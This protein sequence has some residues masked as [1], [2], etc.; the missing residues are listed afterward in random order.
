MV[1][2]TSTAIVAVMSSSNTLSGGY[3]NQ[4]VLMVLTS[5]CAIIFVLSLLHTDL[6]KQQSELSERATSALAEARSDSLT[7]LNNRK[8]LVECLERKIHEQSYSQSCSS[9][10]FMDLDHFKNVN[11][12]LG[13]EAGDTLLEE[14]AHRLLRAMPDHECFR[15]GGDEFA[16]ILHGLGLEAAEQVCREVHQEVTRP[17]LLAGYP[18]SVGCSMGIAEF[19]HDLP[20]SVLMSRA[21]HAMYKAKFSRTSIAKFDKVMLAAATRTA[22]LTKKLREV[23]VSRTGIS[24]KYQPVFDRG[25]N[26]VELEGLFRWH[27]RDYHAI[28]TR[29]AIKIARQNHLLDQISL[30]VVERSQECLCVNPHLNLNINVEATQLLDRQFPDAL[31]EKLQLTGIACSRLSLEIGE[32]DLVT[33]GSKMARILAQLIDRG[34]SITVDDFGSSNA[35]L[36]R[37][38]ELGVS[39]IKFDP[40]ILANARETG[41]NDLIKAKVSLG[42]SLGMSVTC[43]GISSDEDYRIAQS[44]GCDMYQGYRF[45]RPTTIGSLVNCLELPPMAANG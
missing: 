40:S 21:D 14:T 29:E 31:V 3:Q 43:K 24:T 2:L 18:V 16:F 41:S 39:G 11:D 35:S 36:M 10:V 37:L 12:T 25:M 23:L 42:H 4:I 26:I 22:D 38:R 32:S 5:A 34:I 6:R 15:L 13:H 44:A 1:A 20:P 9:L 33:Y 30:F 27:D 45:G 7:N 8:A 28:D 19:C 17:Y